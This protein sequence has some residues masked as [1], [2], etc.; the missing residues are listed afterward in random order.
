MKRKLQSESPSVA[1]GGVRVRV[2]FFCH[3]ADWPTTPNPTKF[4]EGMDLSTYNKLVREEKDLRLSQT[5]ISPCLSAVISRCNNAKSCRRCNRWECEACELDTVTPQTFEDYHEIDPEEY[6]DEYGQRGPCEYLPLS[7]QKCMVC[8]K[9]VCAYCIEKCDG[10][11]CINVACENVCQ[12]FRDTF[13][14]WCRS[15]VEENDQFDIGPVT[16]D[17][18]CRTCFNKVKVN[19]CGCGNRSRYKTFEGDQWGSEEEE[20]EENEDEDEDED[21]NEENAYIE[22]IE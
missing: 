15:V 6:E 16:L 13:C 17:K 19:Y 18:K 8:D 1:R 4:T 12:G 7:L 14:D 5:A 11:D 10:E 21:E 20:E 22:S 9:L 2:S 3:R